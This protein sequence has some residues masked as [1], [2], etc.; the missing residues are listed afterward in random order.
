MIIK[1]WN[2]NYDFLSSCVNWWSLLYSMKSYIWR[3]KGFVL[4]FG[5]NV[6]YF[7]LCFDKSWVTMVEL[8]CNTT[9]SSLWPKTGLRRLASLMTMVES[10]WSNVTIAGSHSEYCN[11]WSNSRCCSRWMDEW[12]FRKEIFDHHCRY[13][14]FYWLCDLGV[15][16]QPSCSPCWPCFCWP[17]RRNGFNGVTPLHFGGFTD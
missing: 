7:N 17:W 1:I 6:T 10:C 11:C 3:I 4:V 5:C 12:S 9:E 16:S 15:C 13:A 14:I 8:C 2:S